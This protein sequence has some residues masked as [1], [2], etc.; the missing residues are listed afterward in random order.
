M[1]KRRG[2]REVLPLVSRA[3][4]IDEEG[5]VYVRVP[6]AGEIAAALAEH[7]A[8]IGRLRAALARS[9]V[10]ELI[11]AIHA[12]MSAGARDVGR[13]RESVRRRR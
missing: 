4:A 2:R 8:N 3:S 6:I 5:R 1:K 13:V 11:D 10:T 12:C 9:E 7:S